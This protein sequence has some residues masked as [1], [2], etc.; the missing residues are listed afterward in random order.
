MTKHHHYP[1]ENLWHLKNI[2]VV[3]HPLYSP[4]WT[5]CNFFLFP[6][7]KSILESQKFK[8]ISETIYNAT[9]RLKA[10]ILEK[11]KGIFKSD[12]TIESTVLRLTSTIFKA[13]NLK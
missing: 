8:D 2:P 1:Y 7:L 12:K 11:H 6:K 4:N 5:S 13:I 10:L 3:P 9:E